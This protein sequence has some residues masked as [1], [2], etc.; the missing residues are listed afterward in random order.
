MNI[1]TLK[2]LISM[3]VSG[4][5][6]AVTAAPASIGTIK[7]PG[8]FRVDGSTII[9]NGTVFN[10][11]LIET[12]AARS[13]IE[14][15][16]AQI[17]LSPE[18]RVK[19][20]SDHTILENGTGVVRDADKHVIE[21]ATL[22]ISPAT[23]DSVLQIEMTS[24]KRVSVSARNGSA[25]VRNAS[26]LLVASLRS[27]MAL[28]FDPQAAAS[29]AVKM[30]GT[31]ESR[32][33]SFFL[34]DATSNIVVELRGANL[35]K[36]AGKKVEVTGSTIAGAAVAAGAAQAVQVTEMKAIGEN[37]TKAAAAG[38]GA[39]AAGAAGA[40]AGAAA[41]IG[42]GATVAIVGGVAVAGT[43][44]GLAAVGTFKNSVTASRQ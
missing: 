4:C 31:L 28:A 44:G 23:K 5:L 13:I 19:I 27:G 35:A 36:F 34:T 42:V 26:G 18:S 15:N 41:G 21:A 8:D 39:A 29:T 25:E 2:P 16:G 11:N 12:K 20:F 24:L 22:R 14:L 3:L 40:G 1:A 38:A 32:G 30:A 43:V 9:G 7:S 17:T 37:L 10:G 6:L 33:G